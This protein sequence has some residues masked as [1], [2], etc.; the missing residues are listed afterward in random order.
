MLRIIVALVL[1]A[2]GLGHSMGVLAAW[3]PIPSGLT[4]RPWLFSGGVLLDSGTGRV[5]SLIWLAALLVTTAG[6]VGLLLQQDWWRTVAVA[7]AVLSLVAIVPWLAV[8]S[9]VASVPW[10]AAMPPVSAF[11]KTIDV[12]SGENDGS[13]SSPES[14]VTRT[15]LPPASGCT[16]R[17]KL[18]AP[19]R[20]EA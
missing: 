6:G 15:A 9:L 4:N 5:W 14:E 18:P 16:Q 12:P 10:L 11:A 7:G 2:H 20:S 1:I 8:L 13:I 19:A 17:S 3:T